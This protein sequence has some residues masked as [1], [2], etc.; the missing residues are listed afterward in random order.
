[1]QPLCSDALKPAASVGATGVV[2][3]DRNRRAAYKIAIQRGSPFPALSALLYL[4]RQ[5]LY[6]LS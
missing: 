1:M 3:D 6:R 2:D 4:K 5:M